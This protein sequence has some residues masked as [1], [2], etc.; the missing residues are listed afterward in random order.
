MSSITVCESVVA[1]TIGDNMNDKY[2]NH[3]EI[4]FIGG[5]IWFFHL[6]RTHCPVV[7]RRL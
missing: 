7:S 6:D 1:A 4:L 5:V 3:T 2:L